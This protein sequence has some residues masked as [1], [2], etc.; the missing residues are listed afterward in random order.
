MQVGTEQEVEG[1][2]AAFE[3]LSL[4]GASCLATAAWRADLRGQ[5]RRPTHQT[6]AAAMRGSR[7]LPTEVAW[8]APPRPKRG[9]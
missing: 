5:W 6:H 7:V 2:N 4:P 3:L 8:V 1:G 9:T